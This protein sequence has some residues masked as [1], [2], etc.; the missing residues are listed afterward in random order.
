VS[1][2]QSVLDA[3]VLAL[4]ASTGVRYVTQNLEQWWNWN[5]DRFPGCRVIDQAEEKKP[6]AYWGSTSVDDMEGV[7]TIS[8]SG[9]VADITN[10]NLSTYR[11]DLI[12]NIEKAVMTSSDVRAAVA[13]VW[14][15]TVETDEGVLDNFG[16]CD[17]TFKAR[18]HYNHGN[19]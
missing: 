8:V 17:C 4:T 5:S 16:W 9:Y 3:F 1:E 11:S 6:F 13:D 10:Q 2:R 7:V 19:P 15:V 18:Y 14:P 12:A